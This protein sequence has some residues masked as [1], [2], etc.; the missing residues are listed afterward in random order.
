[1]LDFARKGIEELFSVQRKLV[2]DI[3]A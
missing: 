2:G 1:M 3:L